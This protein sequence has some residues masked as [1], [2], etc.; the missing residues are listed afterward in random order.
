MWLYFHGNA[1]DL[2]T[3]RGFMQTLSI[4]LE[5]HVIGIEYPS[6]G[7]WYKEKPNSKLIVERASK[8]YDY[9]VN[10]TGYSEENIIIFGRSVG[11]GPAVQLASTKNPRLLI[12]LSA[13]TSIKGVASDI[14]KCL[15][16]WIKERYNSIRAIKKIS[17]P[18][19]FVHGREDNVGRFLQLTLK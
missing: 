16:C 15:S 9:L 18:I 6:Y 12:L 2:G 7:V 3:A 13:Y 11:S 10:E 17:C 19:F 1:E 14:W 5:C 8:V 4:H